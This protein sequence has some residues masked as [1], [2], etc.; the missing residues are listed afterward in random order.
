M[1]ERLF[2][3]DGIRGRAGAYPLDRPTV[4]ALGRE[5]GP[6]AR[7]PGGLAPRWS[8]AATPASRRRSSAPGWPRGCGGRRRR[9]LCRH[10]ADPGRSPGWCAVSAP[11]CGVAVSASHNPHQD[12]GI[13]LI[14][15]AGFKWP[16]DDELRLERALAGAGEPG[17]RRRRR[18]RLAPERATLAGLYLDALADTLPGPRPLD[19]LKIVARLRQRRR[20]ALRR[21]AVP[22]ARRRRQRHRRRAPTAATSTSAAAPPSPPH[23][24][25]P[26]PPAGAELGIAFDGDADRAVFADETGAVRDGDAALYLWATHLHARGRLE[27]PRIVATSMSNLGLERALAEAGIGVVRCGVGDRVVVETMRADGARLGGEQSGHLIH[28]GMSTT[29][30]G[31]LTAL[32]LA[33]IVRRGGDGLSGLLAPFHRYP[34]VLLNVRVARKPDLAGLPA[35]AAAAA[36]VERALGADGRLVLRYSGTE[37]LARVM[38][39]G[40]EEAPGRA[41]GRGAGGGHPRRDRRRARRQPMTTLCVN[42]DHVATIR[43]ARGVDYPDPLEAARIAERAGAVGITVHLRQDRRH[44]QDRDVG[45]AARRRRRQAQPGDGGQPR[46]CSPSPSSTAHTR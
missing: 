42:I 2:G 6:A 13:K 7:R 44:I 39:E 33:A 19:G 15:G 38:I 12:N 26:P 1:S 36:R 25:R 43:Q 8:S 45:R 22:A 5:T 14:D 3:T 35:V 23:W 31:L 37:P 27:P 20:R 30:D 11:R 34:Q 46:R 10:A 32:Q 18:R 40:P 9:A 29:G 24:R 41:A 21:A 16:Q 28:L 4:T 17:P